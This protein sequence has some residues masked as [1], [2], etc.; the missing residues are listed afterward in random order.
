MQRW[1]INVGVLALASILMSTGVA[2]GHGAQVWITHRHP[3]AVPIGPAAPIVYVF[4]SD[5]GGPLYS[6]VRDRTDEA[7]A[8]WTGRGQTLAFRS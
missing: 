5:L 4:N 2:L 1:G 8:V 3:I 7:A 6:Q